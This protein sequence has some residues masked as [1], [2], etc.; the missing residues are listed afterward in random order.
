MPVKQGTH[1]RSSDRGGGRGPRTPRVYPYRPFVWPPT[2]STP[3]LYVHTHTHTASGT[4]YPASARP[5]S[6]PPDSRVVLHAPSPQG[7][8]RPLASLPQ[9]EAASALYGLRRDRHVSSSAGSSPS[10]PSSPS[11]FGSSPSSPS[12]PAQIS[13]TTPLLM[14]RRSPVGVEDTSTHER[15]CTEDCV[16]QGA[17]TA[18]VCRRECGTHH[19]CCRGREA[20]GLH[21]Y[22]LHVRLHATDT[23]LGHSLVI[24]LGGMPSA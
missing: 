22:T 5:P 8:A 23:R 1:D 20:R 9:C 18:C 15:D 10:S 19:D 16:W 4:P 14:W 24:V 21:E 13:S 11:S 17:P 3:P 2:L 7:G 6:A 12:S